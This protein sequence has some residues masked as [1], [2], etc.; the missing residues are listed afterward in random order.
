[1]TTDK[2]IKRINR[3]RSILKSAVILTKLN[4]CSYR[5]RM[6]SEGFSNFRLHPSEEV[7]P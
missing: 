2:R 3:I 6:K 5:K 4:L 1:M 7:Y